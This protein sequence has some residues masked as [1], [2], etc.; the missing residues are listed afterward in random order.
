MHFLCMPF[1]PLIVGHNKMKSLISTKITK[2]FSKRK[3]STHYL[4]IG[5]MIVWLIWKKERSPRFDP[6]ITFH[7]TNFQH[8]ENTSIKILKRGSPDI[9]NFQPVLQFCL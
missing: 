8:F 1:Q 3:M 4:N 7:K 5:H 6:F 2:I 9:L